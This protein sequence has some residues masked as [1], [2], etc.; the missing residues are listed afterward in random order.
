MREYN[1]SPQGGTR[2][3]VA[4]LDEAIKQRSGKRQAIGGLGVAAAGERNPEDLKT[5]PLSAR[6]SRGPRK[7]TMAARHDDI[8][9]VYWPFLPSLAKR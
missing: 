9:L 2:G 7:T 3:E 5:D 1:R 6:P 8:L 4:L